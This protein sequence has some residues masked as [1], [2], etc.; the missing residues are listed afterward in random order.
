MTVKDVEKLLDD[1]AAKSVL[2]ANNEDATA[3]EKGMY[4]SPELFRRATRHLYV[5]NLPETYV[6]HARTP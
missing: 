4:E 5:V 6:L 3:R 2:R 1:L